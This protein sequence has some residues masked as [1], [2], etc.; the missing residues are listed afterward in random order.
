MSQE[1]VE[2]VRRLLWDL[3]VRHTHATLALQAAIHPAGE[4]RRLRHERKM[5]AGK[6][7]NGLARLALA[8]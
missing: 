3:D 7:R 4:A 6:A 1:N 2:L 8:R 5:L